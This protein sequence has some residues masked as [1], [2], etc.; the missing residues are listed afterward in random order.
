MPNKR[1]Q[2]ESEAIRVV[3]NCLV[4]RQKFLS[5]KIYTNP[6]VAIVCGGLKK[7]LLHN[8]KCHVV[9]KQFMTTDGDYDF[10]QCVAANSR[11]HL[12]STNS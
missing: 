6:V 4:C 12:K 5:G 11:H 1:I 10:Q 2:L 9:H 7:H 8:K 3:L